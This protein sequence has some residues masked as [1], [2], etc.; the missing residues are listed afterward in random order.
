MPIGDRRRNVS[1]GGLDN[2]IRGRQSWRRM[3]KTIQE[4]VTLVV[5]A[6]FTVLYLKEPF[7]WNHAAGFTLIAAG[8]FLVF[9]KW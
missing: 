8:A 3:L 4:V 6:G 7:G 5:F 9:L 1:L 2:R